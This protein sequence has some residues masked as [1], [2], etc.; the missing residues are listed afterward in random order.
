MVL[1]GGWV[2]LLA[3]RSGMG[4]KR[5]VGYRVGDKFTKF[6]PATV[7]KIASKPELELGALSFQNSN[8][9]GGVA[10]TARRLCTVA[11]EGWVAVGVGVGV[12]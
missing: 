8:T 3:G 12:G 7:G 6:K 10:A 1:A 11:G 5:V 2:D 4:K 9:S